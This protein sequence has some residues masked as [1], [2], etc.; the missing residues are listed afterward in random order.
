MVAW[1]PMCCSATHLGLTMN[2]LVRSSYMQTI[3]AC[4][5]TRPPHANTTHYTT[6]HT[7][8]WEARDSGTKILF[9]YCNTNCNTLH[10]TATRSSIEAW[11]LWHKRGPQTLGSILQH[12]LQHTT[13]HC[14]VPH[15]GNPRDY[16][17]KQLYTCRSIRQKF[18]KVSSLLLNLLQTTR[19]CEMPF[20][21]HTYMNAKSKAIKRDL[22]MPLHPTSC[23]SVLQRVAA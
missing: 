16:Q 20:K 13:Q 21:R 8:A 2:C 6:L 12:T 14:S 22:D 1:L 15:H 18:S 9:T 10:T 5:K 11:R 17:K 19:P 7:A 3:I 23:C 4:T